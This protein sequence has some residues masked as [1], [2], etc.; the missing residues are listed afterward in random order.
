M[1]SF[2]ISLFLYTSGADVAPLLLLLVEFI[3]TFGALDLVELVIA[4]GIAI[5]IAHSPAS[6]Q[7]GQ[8]LTA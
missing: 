6:L 8:S 2:F 4:P 1:L 3:A 7:S 5:V